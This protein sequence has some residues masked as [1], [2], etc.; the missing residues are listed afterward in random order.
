[1]ATF[2]TLRDAP[3]TLL[4]EGARVIDP[5]AATDERRDLAV[6]DG[7]LAPPGDAPRD[8]R[9]IDAHRL[10]VAP[11]LCDLHTHLREPGNEAA[12]TVATAARAAAHGGFTTICAMPNT[13]PPLDDATRV[14]ATIAL[15]ESVSCRVR[16]IAAAT[17]GRAGEQ[18][19]GYGGLANAGAVAVC[20]DGASIASAG[21]MRHALEYA[22][23]VGLTVIQHADD[24]ELSRGSGMRAGPTATLLGLGGWPAS[25]EATVVARDIELARETGARLHVT[26]V[27]TRAALDAVRAARLAG[28]PV[29]CDVTPHHLA[30]TD[31]WVAG[32]RRFAWEET[33]E[34]RIDPAAAYDGATRVNPP[35]TTRDDALALLAGVQDG[36]V[37]AIAT[38]HAPHTLTDKLVEFANAAR[39]ISGL[40]TDLSLTLAAVTAGRIGLPEALAALSTRSAALL[41]EERS[42]LPGALAEVVV[43][44]PA[45]TWR[46][47][48]ST[49]ESKGKNTPLLGMQLPG[50]VLL[51]VAAG[52][53]TYDALG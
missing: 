33:T 24:A 41:G 18:L 38:D 16:V 12:E 49:L 52:R 51:T 19:T 39:G 25:A 7:R 26:H 45:A 3:A 28:V 1:M 11:G 32:D 31:R 5:Q 4:L 17:R 43:F 2:G 34:L 13:D 30:L 48:E 6:V 29:T 37:D 8:A 42:L 40:E 20:D 22:A 46:V 50:R 44:D 15:A 27:S 9:R 10:V 53:V 35:L 36:T 14:R 47:D 21:V 23:Q